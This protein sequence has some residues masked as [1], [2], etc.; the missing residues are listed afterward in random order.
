MSFDP[1]QSKSESFRRLNPHLFLGGVE[2]AQPKPSQ[3]REGEDP[4]LEGVQDRARF[5]VTLIVVNRRPMDS[6]DNLRMAC[7]P[8]VDAITE[9]LGFKTDD[10]PRLEWRYAQ[11]AERRGN[12]AD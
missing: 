11:T 4:Q 1:H 9:K 12:C 3:R 2:T 8:L 7:K 5:R 10:D 6:H